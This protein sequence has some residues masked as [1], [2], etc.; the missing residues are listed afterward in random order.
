MDCNGDV[1]SGNDL[2]SRERVSSKQIHSVTDFFT[3][4]MLLIAEGLLSHMSFM[5][6]R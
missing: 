5:F 1:K 6:T 4:E 3:Y 2:T